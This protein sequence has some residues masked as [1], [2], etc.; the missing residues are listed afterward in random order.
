MPLQNDL[1]KKPAQG[2]SAGK[3]QALSLV[4]ALQ[5]LV[6]EMAKVSTEAEALQGLHRLRELRVEFLSGEGIQSVRRD[7]EALVSWVETRLE[8]LRKQLAKKQRML[9]GEA[10]EKMARQREAEGPSLLPAELIDA[11][12]HSTNSKEPDLPKHSQPAPDSEKVKSGKQPGKVRDAHSSGRQK[13]Q[14]LHTEDKP[15]DKQTGTAAA[16][17]SAQEQPLPGQQ[18]PAGAGKPERKPAV[19][20]KPEPERKTEWSLY[21]KLMAHMTACLQED[22]GYFDKLRRNAKRPGPRQNAPAD[23]Q[24][25][26]QHY[27]TVHDLGKRLVNLELH[28]KALARE[29]EQRQRIALLRAGAKELKC[30]LRDLKS[31][32]EQLPEMAAEYKRLYGGYAEQFAAMKPEKGAALLTERKPAAAQEQQPAPRQEAAELPQLVLRR[33]DDWQQ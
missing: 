20:A 26:E 31:A 11:V 23:D 24:K 32:Q 15:T 22:P 2:K 16:P 17:S 28:A 10:M 9:E 5:S 30:F 6:S 33:E 8:Q 18:A 27:R 25:A 7:A 13:Q 3:Q 29:P 4:E 21:E 1:N 14:T 12:V 19:A